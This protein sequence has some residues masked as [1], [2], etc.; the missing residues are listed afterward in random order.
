VGCIAVYGGSFDP[1]HLAHRHAVEYLAGQGVFDKILVVPVYEHALEK[2][3]APYEHRIAMCEASMLVSPIAEVSPI[4]SEL[5]PPNYTLNTLE[6]LAKRNPGAELRLVVGA[7]VLLDADRWH[8]FDEVVK[9][10]P[11]YPLGRRGVRCD[12]APEAVLPEISSTQIRSRLR[13]RPEGRMSPKLRSLLGHW[14][15]PAVIDYI[16]THDLYR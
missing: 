9:L 11:L 13:R 12:A 7:D 2:R 14:L 4:E 1:P 8:A 15:V 3:V 6:T 5:P 10:A 16:E